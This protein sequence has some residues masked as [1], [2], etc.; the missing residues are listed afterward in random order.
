VAAN[1]STAISAWSTTAGSNQPDSTDLASTLREDLQ[2]IQA[3]V[4][5]LRTSGTIAS[6]GTMDLATKSEEILSVSGTTTITALGTVSAGMIK[7]LVFEGALT[8]THNAGSLI[9]PGG[10]SI[11]TAAGDIA[12]ML[13][14]GSGNWRCLQYQ[15]ASGYPVTRGWVLLDSEA[16]SNSASI[17]LTGA[18][19]S[20]YVSHRIVLQDIVLSA[21]AGVQLRTGGGGIDTAS[22][23]VYQSVVASGSTVSTADSGGASAIEISSIVEATSNIFCCEIEMSVNTSV[24]RHFFRTQNNYINSTGVHVNLSVAGYYNGGCDRVQLFPSAGVFTSGNFRL[25]GLL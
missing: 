22:N 2:A 3:A 11:V 25:Y 13:S 6:S 14:L 17:T 20:T 5:Y 23:Y 15:R 8:F 21:D 19:G 1:I 10:A 9:L 24:S 12:T 16:A 18:S 7:V 4:R